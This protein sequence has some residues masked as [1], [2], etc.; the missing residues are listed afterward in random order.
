VSGFQPRRPGFIGAIYALVIS[1]LEANRDVSDMDYYS[2]WNES[3]HAPVTVRMSV[4]Y[5]VQTPGGMSSRE[6]GL[7]LTGKLWNDT[8]TMPAL[9]CGCLDLRVGSSYARGVRKLREDS[10]RDLH[11]EDQAVA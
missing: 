4:S 1:Y 11:P 10:W 3:P 2:T 8:G 9:L 5:S 7:W 6:R